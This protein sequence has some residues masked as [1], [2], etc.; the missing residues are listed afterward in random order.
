MFYSLEHGAR[1]PKLSPQLLVV[2]GFVSLPHMI[3]KVMPQCKKRDITEER[4][5]KKPPINSNTSV[6]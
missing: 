5:Y 6:S 4:L 1:F 2:F 3:L